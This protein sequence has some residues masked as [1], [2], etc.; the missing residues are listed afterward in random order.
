MFVKP[1]TTPTPHQCAPCTQMRR[2]LN[3][4]SSD[5]SSYLYNWEN[6]R[7]QLWCRSI[8]KLCMNNMY[9]FSSVNSIK[10]KLNVTEVWAEVSL[11]SA[12]RVYW[13]FKMLIELI[14]HNIHPMIDLLWLTD[15]MFLPSPGHK[16]SWINSCRK[17]WAPASSQHKRLLTSDPFASI[18][19]GMIGSG[20]LLISSTIV[21]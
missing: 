10:V 5:T 9:V 19:G 8:P 4:I 21:E 16:T 17:S 18:K 2:C 12:G 11:G 15:Q 13:K 3:K 7:T 20:L 6:M 14:L 1:V